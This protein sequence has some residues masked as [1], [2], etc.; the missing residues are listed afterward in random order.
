VTAAI[1]A[2][3]LGRRF[4][5]VD[6]VADLDLDVPAGSIYGFLGPNGAG[7]TT[8]IRLLLGLLRP[9]TGEAEVLGHDV[10]TGAPA[11]REAVGVLLETD[12]L[13]HR[14]TARQNL[15][16]YGRVARVPATDRARRIRALLEHIDLWDRRDEPVADFSFGMRKKLALA[17]AFL[18]RPTL[19][20]LDE[21]TSGL[22]TPTAVGLRQELLRL[23]RD[24]GVT[25]FLTTHNLLEA[26]K[27]CDRVAVIRKGRRIAEGA[28]ASIRARSRRSLEVTGA[29]FA[30]ELVATV[31][32]MP[33][34]AGVRRENG[35]LR[36][37]LAEGGETAP[38][39]RALVVG[40]A[41]V[42]EARVAGASLEETFLALL[43]ESDESE[44]GA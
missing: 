16:F 1:R 30:P 13:Y 39:V 2:R 4:G 21:P 38:I 6:A 42:A 8:T 22:D 27:L 31:V 33:G 15:D 3:G 18:H 36:I 10:R 19:L 40:G 12:G 20:F 34:V 5:G 44:T 7:K 28:P 32:G 26:E 17:R 24:E 14:L 29:G 23:A 25:V 37:E 11:V 43:E 35:R 41:E 9:T